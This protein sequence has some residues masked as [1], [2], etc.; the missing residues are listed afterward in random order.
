MVNFITSILKLYFQA[1][2]KHKKRMYSYIPKTRR[3]SEYET[4]SSQVDLLVL[5]KFEGSG[6]Q[7]RGVI[8]AVQCRKPAGSKRF[9][10]RFF[11]RGWTEKVLV[12]AFY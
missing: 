7:T 4:R 6:S 5:G 3:L 10:H 11:F 2:K 12:C 1:T 9:A 8:L